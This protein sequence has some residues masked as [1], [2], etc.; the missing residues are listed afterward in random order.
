MG[1]RIEKDAVKMLRAGDFRLDDVSLQSTS[2]P[3]G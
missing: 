2:I 3:I 1:K